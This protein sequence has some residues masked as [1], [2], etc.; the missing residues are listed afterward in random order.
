MSVEASTPTN[1][2]LTQRGYDRGSARLDLVRRGESAHRRYGPR[3][4]RLVK[5]YTPILLATM[6]V[7]LLPSV[8]RWFVY[9]LPPNLARKPSHSENSDY[10][11]PPS[12]ARLTALVPLDNP[13]ARFG[14][15]AQR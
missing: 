2:R 13:V 15:V 8:L 6:S 7:I 12:L 9:R 10:D 4:L 3:R 1:S 11:L 5:M 14:R